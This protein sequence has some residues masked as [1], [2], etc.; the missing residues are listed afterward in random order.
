MG[1][2][3]EQVIWWLMALQ[4]PYCD[5]PVIEEVEVTNWK[6]SNYKVQVGTLISGF[7]VF[8][9]VFYG[10]VDLNGGCHHKLLILGWN[11]ENKY[12]HEKQMSHDFTCLLHSNLVSK[13]VFISNFFPSQKTP[14]QPERKISANKIFFPFYLNVG[15]TSTVSRP[16][17]ATL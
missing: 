4:A 5:L 11:V 14:E 17:R 16:T 12:V 7:F 1:G 10:W 13:F 2:T 8:V 15:V 9:F 3:N 6:K